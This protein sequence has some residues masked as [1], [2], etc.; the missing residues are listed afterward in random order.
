MVKIISF[1]SPLSHACKDGETTVTLSDVVDQLHDNNR[2]TNTGTTEG[3][4]FSTLRERTNEINNLDPCF[5][6]LSLCILI[7]QRRS[8]TVNR[9]TLGVRNWTA[10][11][12]G[13]TSD[14]ENTA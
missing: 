3:T 4:D 9:I 6:N 13:V 1:A 8:R 10:L 2:F 7:H 11:I 5:Q 14:I 12:S